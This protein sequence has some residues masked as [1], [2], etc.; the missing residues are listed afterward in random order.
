[1]V[2]RCIFVFEEEPSIPWFDANAAAPPG[3]RHTDTV[4]VRR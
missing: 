3:K 1:M 2:T 4:G